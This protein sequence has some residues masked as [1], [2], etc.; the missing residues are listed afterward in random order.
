MS[1]ALFHFACFE[2]YLLQIDNKLVSEYS[3]NENGPI[4]LL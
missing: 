3:D 4:L 1:V 2:V